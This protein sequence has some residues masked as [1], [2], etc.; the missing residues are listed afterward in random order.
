MRSAVLLTCLIGFGSS[1]NAGT[2]DE[3]DPKDSTAPPK[4]AAEEKA[5]PA[6]EV[7]EFLSKQLERLQGVPP[8]KQGP[9]IKEMAIEARSMPPGEGREMLV[10]SLLSLSTEGHGQEVVQTVV[11]TAEK[12]V[13]E[14]KRPTIPGETV[15]L[16][17]VLAF[18]VHYAGVKAEGKSEK[19]KAAIRK[20]E[21]ADRK[22]PDAQFKLA[23]LDGKTWTLESCRGKFIVVNFWN[24]WCPPCV[25]ELPDLEALSRRFKNDVVVLGLVDEEADLVREFVEKNS[26][27]Y[28]ILLD[29]DGQARKAFGVWGVP[30]TL[31]Y[32][33]AGKLTSHV[34]DLRTQEQFE[35]ALVKA[36]LKYQP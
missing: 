4:P 29:K 10:M 31:V 33:R 14:N 7:V 1:L 24:T 17:E 25:R 22:L 27:T 13:N 16:D 21:E 20:F 28:P 32:D 11:E 18:I 35:A 6:P 26:I 36:G 3:P 8:E 5:G 2:A 30:R 23:D 12:I 19:Y 15:S 34:Y 9:V